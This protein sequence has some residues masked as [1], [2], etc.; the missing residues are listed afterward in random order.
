MSVPELLEVSGMHST[1][2]L[3]FFPCQLW[4]G[5]VAPDEVLFMGQIEL[6]YVHMLKWIVLKS[7]AF[8]R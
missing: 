5:D 4:P 8:V 1:P 2:S 6:N 3:S 7:T